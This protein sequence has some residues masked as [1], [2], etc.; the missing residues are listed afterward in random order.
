MKIPFLSSLLRLTAN[1]KVI[2]KITAG[3][4]SVIAVFIV[5]LALSFWNFVTIGHEVEE[6]E[7]AA[8]ELSLAADIEIKFLKMIRAAR[9]FVQKGDTKSET[10][11]RKYSEQLLGAI[12]AAKKGITIESHQALILEVEEAFKSYF[13]DFEIVTKLKHEHDTYITESLD[14]TGDKMIADLDEFVKEAEAESNDTLRTLSFEAREHA[15]LIQIYTGRLLLEQKQ[16]YGAKISKEFELFQNSLDRMASHLH[17]ERERELHVELTEL[18]ATYHDIYEKIRHDEEEIARLMDEEMPKFSAIIIKDTEQLENEAAEHE[19]EV[20]VRALKEIALAE[21]ELPIIGGI[22]TVLGF[23]LAFSI[24]R[25]ISQPVR[26]TTGVMDALTHGNLSVDAP[27]QDRGDEIGEMARAVQIFKDNMIQN[28]KMR[29]EQERSQAERIQRAE[30]V[31]TILRDF[32]HRAGGMMESVSGASEEIRNT[33]LEGSL[34][35]NEAGGKSFEVALAS[36]R[37]VDNI[38]NAAAAAEELSASINEIAGQVSDS[39]NMAADAV[40][41]TEEANSQI[42]GL[43]DASNKIGEIVNL[44]SEIAEQTNLLALNATIE[45]ARAGDA[46]KGF[47][48]VASEVKSLASQT[49]NAT[50]EI[51]TQVQSIQQAVS[52]AVGAVDRVS[53]VI[54]RMS[55]VTTGIAA[56]VEEQSAATQEIARTTATVS[57][58]ATEVLGS[59]AQMTQTSAQSTGKSIGV[60]WSASDLDETIGGFSR[61]LEEFLSSAR[62]V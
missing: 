16:E 48:V 51:A 62:T 39:T 15:F 29:A 37:T 12:E 59:I 25:G 27:A 36:E 42:R 4:G 44:I 19:H 5:V 43:A 10:E 23:I 2:T 8:I 22:G 38:N 45:A 31:D 21:A 30:T 33:S 28:E 55:G 35:Q 13:A 3:F 34:S 6:M 50:D 54:E 52:G 9:E 1:W 47:A 24:A 57:G 14:P 41:E 40:S 60:L 18:R 17:T 7:S 53:S 32:E 26:S 20:S 11:T 56:A 61:E 49:A 58:D 46:G